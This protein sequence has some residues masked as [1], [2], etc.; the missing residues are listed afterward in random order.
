LLG[1]HSLVWD[2]AQ[3]IS[4]KDPDFHRRDLWNAIEM[5]AYPEYELGVQLLPEEAQDKVGFD[6]L[7]ATKIWPEDVVPVQRIG[8]LTLNRNPDNFFAE[9]EQV[10]VHPGH[11]V[12]GIDFSDDPLLQGRLF[13]YLDT[14]INRFGSPNFHQLPI[15]QPKSPVNNRQQDS[16]MRSTN[17]PGKANYEPNSLDDLKEAT[18]KQG[19]FESYPAPISGAKLRERSKT[20]S[21]HYSQA[22]LFFKSLTPP[23]Q[24]HLIA[25]LQFELGKVSNKKVQERMLEHLANVDG[26]MTTQVA[27]YIGLKAPK[28]QVN[29]KVGK[30]KGLSQEESPG[31]TIKTRKIAILTSDGVNAAEVSRMLSGMKKNGATAEVI[32]PHLGELAGGEV[33]VDN[34]YATAASVLYD[35]VYVPGGKESVK[36]LVGDYEVRHFVREAYNHGKAI[37]ASGEGAELLQ[38]VGIT[39]GPGVVSG[40]SSSDFTQNF[41]DAIK[42]RH[43][44]RVKSV[45]KVKSN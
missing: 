13:S 17:R 35:A 16:F 11:I 37:A 19:G 40:K 12:P 10:A 21:D 32:A 45:D 29:M 30:T 9:T 7:D 24:D 34:T 27:T 14:Q 20:F 25:A 36:Q 2:E 38:A 3:K 15:N 23:E 6:I 18:S 8:K 43:W 42:H 31:D 41:V 26:D 4:G 44:N 5:G 28:G 33:K 1:V 39:P 22:T